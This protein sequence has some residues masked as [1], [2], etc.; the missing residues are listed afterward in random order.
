MKLIS[1]TMV[2]NEEEIIE[3]FIRYNYNFVDK[4]V[5]IDNG[6]TDNT[7]K[8]VNLLKQEGYLIDVFDESLEPYNQFKLDNKYLNKIISEYNADLILP[9]DADEF[10]SGKQNPRYILENLDLNRIYYVNWKWYVLTGKE[11]E[12][13]TFIPERIKYRFEK[14]AWNYSD[15]SPV[16]KVII[17]TN[18]FKKNKLVLTMGHHDVFSRAN[19]DINKSKLDNLWIAHYRTISQRQIVSKTQTYVIRD[20]ATLSNNIETAQ[21]TNQL[22]EIERRK[23]KIDKMAQQISYAG[24]QDKIVY[25]PLE[26]D[27]CNKNSN[28]MKYYN[29]SNESMG[30]LLMK[31][32]QEMAIRAYNIESSTK[33]IFLKPIVLWLDNVRKTEYIL[34]SPTIRLS[35]IT[36]LF[37]VRGYL[38][39]YKQIE[40]LK[41][42]YK[43]IVTAENVKFLPYS[44]IVV[45]DENNLK[46]VK[47]YLQKNGIS[48]N[49]VLTLKEYRKKINFFGN[50]YSYFIFLPNLVKR[51]YRYIKRNGIHKFISKI[52][53]KGLKN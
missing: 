25:D 6:C 31:T 22:F 24:Y 15:G 13:Q 11:D 7:M 47:K 14:Y 48:T 35:L 26:L 10:I 39:N 20:I 36:L 18:Y 44:Y 1:F 16:T 49:N 52:K 46:K 4:M 19:K 23:E 42:N 3:S 34:P 12:S 45:T 5:I 50:V 37:N 27:Y 29:Y 28:V 51:T 17:P 9:L 33:F 8:I 2:N 38:T 43:L 53:E 40:F 21:R 30:E 41:Y 32:G